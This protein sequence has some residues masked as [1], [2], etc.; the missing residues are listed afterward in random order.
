[1]ICLC[2]GD[3]VLQGNASGVLEQYVFAF[4]ARVSWM[5]ALLPSLHALV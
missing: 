4:A 1:M 3:I 5:F 2:A